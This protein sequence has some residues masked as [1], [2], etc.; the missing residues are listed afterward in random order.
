MVVSILGLR[1]STFLGGR[2]ISV[3]VFLCLVF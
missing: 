1:L 3:V 2:G